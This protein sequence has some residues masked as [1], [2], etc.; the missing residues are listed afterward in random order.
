MATLSPVDRPALREWMRAN[1][2][3]VRGLAAVLG[4]SFRTVQRWRDGTSEIPPFLELALKSLE[5]GGAR[6][7]PEPERQPAQDAP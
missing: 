7:E 6:G 2:Y 4:V 3:T 1:R 5:R